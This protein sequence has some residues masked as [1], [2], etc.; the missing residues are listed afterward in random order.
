MINYPFKIYDF[1]LSFFENLKEGDSI[2]VVEELNY[3]YEDE[4]IHEKVVHFCNMQ[5]F[6]FA[7]TPKSLKIVL[8]GAFTDIYTFY[9]TNKSKYS[10]CIIFPNEIKVVKNQQKCFEHINKL[11]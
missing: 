9:E 8:D 1:T 3:Y 2:L 4:L 7:E 11:N 10:Y 5:I 6:D